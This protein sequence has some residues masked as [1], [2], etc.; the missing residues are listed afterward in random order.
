MRKEVKAALLVCLAASMWG[1]DGVVLTPRLFH[2]NVPFVVF[3]LHFIPFVGMS[4]TFGKNEIGNINKISKSDMFYFF[5]IALFG[6]SLGTL[7]IV[8]ALFLVNFKHLTVVTLLQKLQPIFAIILAR[9]I[10]GE[11]LKKDYLIW[12]FIALIG[13]YF[14]TFEFNLPEVSVGENL[15]KAAMY[16]I[17]AAFSFGSATVFGKR[18]LKNS[19]FRTAL[20]LRYMLTSV[21]MLFITFFSGGFIAL[22]TITANEWLIIFIIAATT[23]SGA[24]MLYYI[25]LR[26]ITAKV[27]TICE[28]CFPLSSV[29][30][31][32]IFN[33]H[34]LSP[35]QIISAI[36]MIISILKITKLK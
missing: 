1:F 7:S 35:I 5:C 13:G 36:V 8:K 27:A 18:I 16:S 19:S 24:I 12:G 25:G 6:G 23:G 28:L 14:L 15:P 32:Y 34:I 10:L 26:N 21:I 31:D 9:I 3:I 2:L 33:G 22:K 4:F 11:R 17:L 29:I 20:Y 30:F